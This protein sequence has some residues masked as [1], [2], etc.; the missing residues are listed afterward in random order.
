MKPLDALRS[1]LCDHTGLVCVSMPTA[2]AL[3]VQ[4]ALDTLANA[5]KVSAK[6]YGK[7]IS[8][9]ITGTFHGFT[10]TAMEY[11]GGF[12]PAAVALVEDDA[13]GQVYMVC[14]NHMKFLR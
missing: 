9:D 7:T 1:V 12:C 6:A 3:V 13:D 10:T 4:D 2:D 8:K 14:P 5:T 11:E